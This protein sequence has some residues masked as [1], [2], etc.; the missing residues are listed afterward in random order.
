MT[1]TN[2]TPAVES[3]HFAEERAR[4]SVSN[5]MTERPWHLRDPMPADLTNYAVDVYA[6]LLVSLTIRSCRPRRGCSGRRATRCSSTSVAWSPLR[7]S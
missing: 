7:T 3:G 2:S 5:W 1:T 6:G 4:L